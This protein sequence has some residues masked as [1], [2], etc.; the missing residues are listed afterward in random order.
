V[1]VGALHAMHTYLGEIVPTERLAHE[2]CEIEITKLGK[3]IGKQ[4][5]YIAAYGGLRFIEFQK[6][7]TIHTEKIQVD[8]KSQRLLNNNFMLFFTGISRKSDTILE[9]QKRKIADRL[10]TL[11]EIKEMAYTARNEVKAANIDV[12]GELLHKSWLL[13]KQLAGP[14][15][16][17]LI[18]RMYEAARRAGAIGGKLT[19]AG[20]GGFL[21]LYC[22]HHKQDAVRAALNPLQELPFQLE[23]DG[24]KV[25]FNYRR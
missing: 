9:E 14:I 25:I 3:P 5:Q 24:T 11:R 2:A 1:T 4:D 15:S 7:G 23:Q 12:L 20:G 6:D 13:K 17:G 19:G 8:E 10:E 21:L 22:P 18:D 16:N